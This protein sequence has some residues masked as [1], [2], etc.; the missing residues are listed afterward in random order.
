MADVDAK[1]ESISQ[2]AALKSALAA[3]AVIATMGDYHSRKIALEAIKDIG[4]ENDK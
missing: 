2:T 1:I 3:L 4:R